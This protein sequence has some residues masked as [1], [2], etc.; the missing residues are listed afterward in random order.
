MNQSRKPTT[1][2]LGLL[3]IAIVSGSF[4]IN[5]ETGIFGLKDLLPLISAIIF[6][7][8]FST[9][10]KFN[11]SGW[12]LNPL[13]LSLLILVSFFIPLSNSNRW[14]ILST[15]TIC[16][17]LP[18]FREIDFRKFKKTTSRVT[19]IFFGLKLLFGVLS[20]VPEYILQFLSFGYDNAFH[21]AIFRYYRAEP[22]FPFG[23]ESP[24]ATDFG[25][26]NTYPSGQGALW[27]FLAEPILGDSLEA[28]KNLVAYAV[29]NIALL[30]LL[31]LLVFSLI[32]LY[33]QKSIL[34]LI[35]IG[36]VSLAI[37]VGYFGIFFTNGFIPYAAGILV[38]LIY[39]RVQSLELSKNSRFLSVFFAT[40]LLLLICPALIA[41][42]FLPGL[43]TTFRYFKEAL[44][45]AS[46][47]RVVS[48]FSISSAL[49]LLGY[50]FQV[51]TSSNFGWRVILSPGG[52][53]K[54]NVYVA[55][56][57][58]LSIVIA[59]GL[60][61]RSTLGN[62]AIQ[63]TFSGAISVI[64]LSLITIIS[65]GSVQ[66]YAVKQLHVWLV[67]GGVCLAIVILTLKIIPKM[68]NLLRVSFV[69]LLILPLLT[70]T[71]MSS[72]WMGNLVGVVLAT[73][74]E[75]KWD[76]QIVN[77]RSIEA[78]LKATSSLRNVSVE[79]LIIRTKDL[80]SDLNS[81]W[82]NSL[83]T[84]PTIT[85]NCFAAF[86]NSAPLTDKEL[87]ERIKGLD[88]TFLILSD[89]GSR[90]T[91]EKESNFQYVLLP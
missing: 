88:G 55:L 77:V 66:Y 70:P 68:S 85:N 27:S 21:F 9:A 6:F 18:H 89:T 90:L 23:S 87:E 75:S 2:A 60:R 31:N 79:C 80:E 56:L 4:L 64:L 15:I 38:L 41:F 83:N 39:L 51:I 25:L 47:V 53:I 73:L 36:I 37:S 62:V 1:V 11:E 71:S 34:D 72:A 61:W 45:T 69:T 33:S 43:V 46:Y 58:F 78:G 30:V 40:L 50:F 76:S 7:S 16:V 22:W 17:L 57:L 86:W 67:L 81:R 3:G 32:Y 54:P 26:F 29:I 91:V 65:T 59:L 82:I 28:E 8:G 19:V 13:F 63:L 10:S 5:F 49:A 52:V 35:F 74:D 14:L 20:R 12:Y 24:W 44:S 84:S 42:L 48:M